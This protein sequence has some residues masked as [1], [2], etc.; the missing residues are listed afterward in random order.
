MAPWGALREHRKARPG[1]LKVA[2]AWWVL[3]AALVAVLLRIWHMVLMKEAIDQ[4]VALGWW[5]A[6]CWTI[7][8]A[9]M[10]CERRAWAANI[11]GAPMFWSKRTGEFWIMLAAF[12]LLLLLFHVGYTRAAS[13][14]RGYFAQ[15]RSL[16][17]DRD[18]D[19]TNDIEHFGAR[20][21]DATFPLGTAL[22]WAPFF[23][24][25][26]VWLGV[27]NLFGAEYSR[28]GFWNPYQ[29]AVGVG[30]F[31]YGFAALLMICGAL[32]RL[33]DR[34]STLVAAL[35]ILLAT[36]VVWYLAVDSSMS[37]GVSL[38]AVTAFLLVWFATG[39]ERRGRDWLA[40]TALSALMTGIRPQNL[41]FLTALGTE[42][43]HVV[44]VD[45]R[46]HRDPV[47]VL[48]RAA[49][50]GLPC[51]AALVIFA[52]VAV[53]VS[54]EGDDSYVLQQDLF[55]RVRVADVLFS[56]RH[57]LISSSPALLFALLGVPLLYS[58]ERTLA[59]GLLASVLAQI[60]LNGTSAAWAGG[61][62]FG[63]RRF[64]E[65]ALPFAFG[66][67][68]AVDLARRRPL[69]PIGLLLGG[70]IGLNLALVQDYRLGTPTQS[71]AVPFRRMVEAV[72][73]RVG[74]PF[75]LPAAAL[76]AWRHDLPLA[77][78]DRMQPRPFQVFRLDVG[79]DSDSP[80]LLGAWFDRERDARRTFRWATQPEALVVTSIARGFDYTLRIVV[81]PFRWPGAPPQTVEVVY[82]DT[83]LG[84][85]ALPR[86]FSQQEF[87]VPRAITL[88]SSVARIAFRFS[89]AR[90]PRETGLSPDDARRLAV[91]F[92][93][94]EL[95]PR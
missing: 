67:A 22:M 33:F 32:R 93:S 16:I 13:D 70:L 45:W 39:E 82:G 86:G 25:A 85:V 58:R 28:D 26:H 20:A 54:E 65:C 83:V 37:H 42:A 95:V 87:V 56:P 53:P 43:L 57:G 91:R 79:N 44:R 55:S 61:A 52:F 18:L 69:A 11:G 77:Q 68:A 1:A 41:L 73:S 7:V 63:A 89:Y 66:L 72:T 49:P 78:F 94:V 12:S 23:L 64:V 76:F 38:F 35:T 34:S 15:V 21:R 40:L 75:A 62:A 2:V 14:G 24:F 48:R 30:T 50:Y 47:R 8:A 9:A 4:P 84:T 92:D 74:N 51:A 60:V 46:I 5:I 29:R 10:A 27:F 80:F 59:L 90:S 81:E 88:S 17:I 6:A 31:I 71:E 3:M 36:P 19:F